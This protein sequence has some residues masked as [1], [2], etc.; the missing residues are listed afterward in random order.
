M[1][2]VFFGIIKLLNNIFVIPILRKHNKLRVQRLV[3]NIE[4][5][6]GD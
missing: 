6:R 2:M 3:G 1:T 5:D 4:L